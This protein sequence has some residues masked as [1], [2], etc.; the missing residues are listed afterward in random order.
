MYL[1]E[2]IAKVSKV[3]IGEA[4]NMLQDIKSAYV[5]IFN[6]GRHDEGVYTLQGHSSPYVLAFEREEDAGRFAQQL[7]ASGDGF[8]RVPPPNGGRAPS[9]ATLPSSPHPA[10]TLPFL[11]VLRRPSAGR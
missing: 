6:V 2:A 9:A 11:R 3:M 4:D 8:V 7:Q 1:R 10:R 5:L